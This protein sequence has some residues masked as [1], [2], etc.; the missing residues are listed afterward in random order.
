MDIAKSASGTSAYA[1]VNGLKLYYEVHGDGPPLV[2]V[3]GGGS[4]IGTTFGRVLPFFARTRKVIA[5]ELQAHGHTRDIDRPLSFEQDADD[6]AF[7]LKE[8]RIPKADVL[9]FSNGASTTLQLAIRH[10]LLV[11][12]IVVASTFFDRSGAPPWFWDMMGKPSFEGMPQAYKDAFLAIVPDPDALHRMYERDVARMQEFQEITK[13]QM[14]GILAPALIII[15]D[16]DVATPEHA[17]E[18]H[19]LIPHSRLA[20]LPG[21]HGDYIG[22]ITTPQDPVLYAATAAMIDKFLGAAS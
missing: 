1:D 7:L 5:V 11:H 14:R 16:Q 6:I 18:M 2:L 9:G 19:R 21:G 17:V 3:H 12:K 20:I 15:G 10:P 4:T 8:L 22:E 13:E